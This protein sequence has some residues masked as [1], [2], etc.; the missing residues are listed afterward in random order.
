MLHRFPL[1]VLLVRCRLQHLNRIFSR[2]HALFVLNG[3][4]QSIDLFALLFI[5]RMHCLRVHLGVTFEV[6]CTLDIF[7]SEEK[8][9]IFNLIFLLAQE[10]V[11]VASQRRVIQVLGI[12]LKFLQFCQGERGESCSHPLLRVFEA[13]RDG[14]VDAFL[15]KLVALLLR[16]HHNWLL[17]LVVGVGSFLLLNL[18][19]LGCHTV[20]RITNLIC[21]H[22][23]PFRDRWTD[24]KLV[25]H[26]ADNVKQVGVA[27][28]LSDAGPFVVHRRCL[29]HLVNDLV[30]HFNDRD[31]LRK[32]EWNVHIYVER[33]DGA[34]EL[35]R[36]SEF[37][38][39]LRPASQRRP[40]VESEQL[41]DL[42]DT[43]VLH[44]V[45]LHHLLLWIHL[46][47]HSWLLHLLLLSSELRMLTRHHAHSRL[48][49]LHPTLHH[50]VVLGS[51]SATVTHHLLLL[52][53][54]ILLILI[55]CLR[56]G[57]TH[58]PI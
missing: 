28:P 34:R 52:E 38:T 35:D 10:D 18:W 4:N 21:Q 44:W 58:I 37:F 49:L 1:L 19:S 24:L 39:A 20:C 41:V 32:L 23:V 31:H 55:V 7:S 43:N 54:A 17:F 53:V 15:G 29:N 50:L 42:I 27:L 30:L 25:V 57:S 47:L 22:L 9:L 8:C 40:S 5:V 14:V 16:P 56:I 11:L 51:H 26:L 48:L 46:L 2:E 45:H 12:F 33:L 3:L 13:F 36:H 6:F